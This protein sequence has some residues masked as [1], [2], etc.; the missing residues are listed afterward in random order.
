LA[1]SGFASQGWS[2]MIFGYVAAGVFCL[3]LLLVFVSMLVTRRGREALGEGC[4]EDCIE[5]I[6]SGFLGG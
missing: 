4:A 2:Q 6:F 5:A 1:E 3:L